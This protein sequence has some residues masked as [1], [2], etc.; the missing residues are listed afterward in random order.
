MEKRADTADIS[1]L[2]FPLI[3]LIFSLYMRK[4][5]ND[6]VLKAIFTKYCAEST[7]L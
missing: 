1:V 6:A 3:V 5:A 2:F 7:V 4:Q